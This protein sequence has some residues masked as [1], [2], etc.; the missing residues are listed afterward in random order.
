MERI[1]EAVGVSNTPV[2]EGLLAMRSEGLVRLVPRRGF[3]VAPFTR[4]DVRDLFWAQA[5]L[6]GELA[7]R[8][9]KM[10]D[11]DALERLASNIEQCDQAI[12]QG[13]KERIT[14]LAHL[15]HREVN[16]AADSPRLALLL[17][18][19]AK[20]LPNRLNA[21]IDG[22][23]AAAQGEHPLVLTALRGRNAGAARTL[24]ERHILQGSDHFIETLEW[25]G[26]WAD[27]ADPAS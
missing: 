21:T 15:F 4:Q 19:I 25:R 2:R 13:N 26:L 10:V 1:A 9:A 5:R 24:M 8:A 18:A 3:V 17:S 12:D 27:G 20:R 11:G 14:D 7:A 6:A 16:L 22:Q 23:I